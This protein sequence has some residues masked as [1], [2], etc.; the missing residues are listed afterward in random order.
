MLAQ[1]LTSVWIETCNSNALWSCVRSTDYGTIWQIYTL[2][3]ATIL[4]GVSYKLRDSAFQK[5]SGCQYDNFMALHVIQLITEVEQ[6]PHLEFRIFHI[7]QWGSNIPETTWG[8]SMTAHDQWHLFNLERLTCSKE[9]II[10]EKEVIMNMAWCLPFRLVFQS[11]SPVL[12][13]K[14]LMQNKEAIIKTWTNPSLQN[15]VEHLGVQAEFSYPDESDKTPAGDMMPRVAMSEV[16]V[17]YLE[18]MLCQGGYR[19]SPGISPD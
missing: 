5:T 10:R 14:S 18:R 12:P 16:I 11:S 13:C 1:I 3:L 7:Y 15:S 2:P 6:Q 4:W 19:H 17:R 9:A 8:K